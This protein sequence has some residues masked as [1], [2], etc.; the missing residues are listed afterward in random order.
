MSKGIRGPEG[1]YGWLFVTPAIVIIGVFLVLP[2]G[3][4]LY[5][6][7]SNWNG[8]GSPLGNSSFVGGVNIVIANAFWLFYAIKYRN[9][10]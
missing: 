8:L 5:V 9:V 7:L 6:S 10:K 4:A 3:L 1:R 2:I